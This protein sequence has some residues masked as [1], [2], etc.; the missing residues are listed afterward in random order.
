[1]QFF[2]LLTLLA[3][4]HRNDTPP[5]QEPPSAATNHKSQNIVFKEP[6]PTANA[7]SFREHKKE[8]EDICFQLR[9]GTTALVLKAF[10]SM[11]GP[12]NEGNRGPLSVTDV[13]QT[14]FYQTLSYYAFTSKDKE[15]REQTVILMDLIAES[16]SLVGFRARR[17][18]FAL[19]DLALKR[20]QDEQLPPLASDGPPLTKWW[21]Q[22]KLRLA[23]IQ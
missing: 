6:V 5:P 12:L 23:L 2:G 3:A 17:V 14:V 4:C 21:L 7:T 10:E 22:S 1:M 19:N 11:L 13:S 16:E 18:L 20:A 8:L 9:S 15:A